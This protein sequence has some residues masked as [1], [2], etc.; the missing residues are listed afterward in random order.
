MARE[1]GYELLPIYDHWWTKMRPDWKENTFD[2]YYDYKPFG[3]RPAGLK[4]YSGAFYGR[5]KSANK[6]RPFWGW[7]DTATQ[8]KKILAQGQWA[9]DPAYAVTRNLKFP[10]D[11][12][13]SLDYIY[14]PYLGI[15]P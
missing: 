7:F 10:V 3:G 1:V 6:A 9:L 15:E 5:E 4:R 2:A 13:F 11:E 14:N 8:K 12:E